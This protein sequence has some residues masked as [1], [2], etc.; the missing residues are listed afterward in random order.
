MQSTL[1]AG[2]VGSTSR[3]SPRIRRTSL[4]A[5]SLARPGLQLAQLG[6]DF[7]EPLNG[8][9]LL[10]AFGG[11]VDRLLGDLRVQELLDADDGDPGRAG[12]AQERRRVGHR[13]YFRQ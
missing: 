9:L 4:T 1:A 10:L 13:V 5:L 2:S 7:F 11:Q 8:P 12:I 3:L 6:R